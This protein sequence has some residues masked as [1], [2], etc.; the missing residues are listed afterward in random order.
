MLTAI[1]GFTAA[2]TLLVIAPGPDSLL[3]LRNT[4]SGG[5]RAGLATAA[6]TLTGLLVWALAAALGVA[7]LV[8]ASELAYTTIRLLG[9]AY[10]VF[11]GIRLLFGPTAPPEQPDT[12]RLR[13]P[14]LTG[15]ATNLF[16]PKVGVFF[17]SFLPVFVPD[18]APVGSTCALFA[19][20]FIV[21]GAV[22]LGTIVAVG[23]RLGAVLRRPVV[24][25][26]IER[27]GGVVMIAFGVRLAASRR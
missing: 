4:I 1:A 3:V 16:N 26:V 8:R 25:R 20:I 23:D 6:G 22:W 24:R 11:L 17:L 5:R 18:G 21:E 14:Y 7:A 13:A 9:A 2:A 12:A 27:M 19:A 15:V 10:L